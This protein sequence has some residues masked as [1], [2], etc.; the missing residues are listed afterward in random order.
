[1]IVLP[2]EVLSRE[3]L[4]ERIVDHAPG[5][6]TEEIGDRLRLVKAVPP[7]EQSRR[8]EWISLER[9]E[10]GRFGGVSLCEMLLEVEGRAVVF[11]PEVARDESVGPEQVRQSDLVRSLRRRE[12]AGLKEDLAIPIVRGSLGEQV[13]AAKEML[14]HGEDVEL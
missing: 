6:G 9:A 12:G 10:N 4:G 7:D 11:L 1:M 3:P 13:D 5:L 14:G 8:K 2:S